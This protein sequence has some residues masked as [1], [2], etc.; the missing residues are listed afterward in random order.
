MTEEMNKRGSK[1]KITQ[2]ISVFTI[3][4]PLFNLVHLEHV[5]QNKNNTKKKGE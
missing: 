1:A 3:F 4:I 5:K 2:N